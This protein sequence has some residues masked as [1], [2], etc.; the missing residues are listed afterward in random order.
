MVIDVGG[1][2]EQKLETKCVNKDTAMLRSFLQKNSESTFSKLEIGLIYS[3]RIPLLLLLFLLVEG[4][5]E[6][7]GSA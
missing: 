2:G 6:K 1:E 5:K 7:E 3:F 4:S